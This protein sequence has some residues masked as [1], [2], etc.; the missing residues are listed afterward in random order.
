MMP[1][2]LEDAETDGGPLGFEKNVTRWKISSQGSGDIAVGLQKTYRLVEK[3]LV[4]DNTRT[5]IPACPIH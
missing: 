1:V 4:L 2:R 3:P 5:P